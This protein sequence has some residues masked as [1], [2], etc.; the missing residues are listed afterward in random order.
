MIGT[1]VVSALSRHVYD[2]HIVTMHAVISPG[3]ND[4]SSIALFKLVRNRI[5]GNVLSVVVPAP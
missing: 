1:W 5:W 2:C 3:F 4:V